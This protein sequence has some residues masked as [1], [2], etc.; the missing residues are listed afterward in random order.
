MFKQTFHSIASLTH[1]CSFGVNLNKWP[2]TLISWRDWKSNKGKKLDQLITK[3]VME[4]TNI[5]KI[6]RHK[7]CEETR[8]KTTRLFLSNS[9]W[10]VTLDWLLP[11]RSHS[12]TPSEKK[13]GKRRKRCTRLFRE[14]CTPA[15]ILTSSSKTNTMITCLFVLHMYFKTTCF[16]YLTFS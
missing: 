3:G 12:P 8:G 15:R 13:I 4:P 11:V 16:K 7:N 6:Y 5:F 9:V 2:I 14:C 10:E 1:A